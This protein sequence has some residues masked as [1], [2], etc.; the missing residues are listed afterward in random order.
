MKLKKIAIATML[1]PVLSHAAIYNS[2]ITKKHNTF[3]IGGFET[4]LE[5]SGWYN[6]NTPVCSFDLLE[7]DVYYGKN[8]LQTETCDQEQEKTI[9]TKNIYDNGEEVIVKIEKQHQMI[10]TSS[11]SN[12]VGIHTETTCYNILANSYS[13]GDGIYRITNGLDVYCDMTTDNGGWTLVFN[14][15]ISSGY[16]SNNAEAISTN[17]NQ[18][19]LTTG[20]YS[21]LNNLET[22]RRDNY[23]QF[24]IAWK[25]YSVRNIWKQ[26]SNPTTDPVSGYSSLSITVSS[27]YWGGL[28]KGAVGGP[29]FI[30]GSVNHSNWF[31]SVGSNVPWGDT[32]VGIPLAT[33]VEA[34]NCGVPNVN[35]WVK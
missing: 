33:D 13:I 4:I 17:Q 27:N 19:S 28:E 26:T 6:I 31:Y 32:C 2:I 5:D 34:G 9:T 20:K 29:T 8:F 35:L 22:F 23:L 10:E 30:D 11:T 16:F 15:D 1:F 14:H 21:I 3:E 18:P 12:V 7:E 24:K 25:G